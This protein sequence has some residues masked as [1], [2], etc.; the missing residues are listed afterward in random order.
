VEDAVL[1]LEHEG[2]DVKATSPKGFVM[3]QSLD[4]STFNY[5]DDALA[6][7]EEG[8]TVK[9]KRL[10]A[11]LGHAKLFVSDKDTTNAKLAVTEITNESLYATD[12]GAL[13][14]VT[15]RRSE[16]TTDEEG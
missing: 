9:A 12:K 13:A 15:L 2:G 3:F 6:E 4:P 7:V 10:Q 14:I 16:E 5:W 1:T 11:A 8:K